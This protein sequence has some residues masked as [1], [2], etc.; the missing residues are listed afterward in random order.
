MPAV[1][2]VSVLTWF[3]QIFLLQP[4]LLFPPRM[5][6]LLIP[7]DESGSFQSDDKKCA[8]IL[9]ARGLDDE[10]RLRKVQNDTGEQ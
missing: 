3:R 6:A 5:Q 10:T 1:A 4:Q 2:R 7:P 9:E 8:K